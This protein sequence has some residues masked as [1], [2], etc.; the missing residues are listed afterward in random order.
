MI[1]DE[2][3]KKDFLD[4]YYIYDG[5]F[6]FEEGRYGFVLIE[7]DKDKLK[8]RD[9][10]PDTRLL[11]IKYFSPMDERF[12]SVTF[13]DIDFS[14]INSSPNPND[15]ITID[16]SGIILSWENDCEGRING[17][18]PGTNRFS[19]ISKVVKV[20][21]SVYALGAWFRIYKRIG[22]G[23]WENNFN[24]LPIPYHM[25]E[26]GGTYHF[27]DMAGFSEDDMYAVGDEGS[28]YH[29][30]GKKWNEAAFPANI[31]LT[32]VTC[33]GNGQVY[34]SD[35][36]CNIWVGR[37]STWEKL[38]EQNMSLSFFDSAWFDDRMWFTNDYG[39]WVLEND[40]LVLAINAEYKPIPEEAA[41]L[42]GRIDISPDNKKMLVCGQKGAAVFDGNTW[43]VL[44]N[45]DSIK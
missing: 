16:T 41:I 44:F 2:E 14:T 40:K 30:D 36:D 42:C 38:V 43:E 11:Y 4:G 25:I 33:A 34:I 39:I 23:E 45:C 35:R 29:F 21:Q 28:V 1:F 15:Y 10:L 6:G 24:T 37:N 20:E 18:I 8:Y 27:Q 17:E 26:N 7:N 31:E 22:E 32:T 5:C 12:Y 13:K 3:T 19:S 9:P